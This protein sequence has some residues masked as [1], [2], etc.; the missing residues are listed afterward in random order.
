MDNYYDI[1]SHVSNSTLGELDMMISGRTFGANMQQVFNFGNLVDALLLEQHLVNHTERTLSL[2]TGGIASYTDDEWTRAINMR[3]AGRNHPILSSMISICDKQCVKM[4]DNFR[5]DGCGFSFSLP[6]RCKYDMVNYLHKIGA[7]L[8]T[9]A[10]KTQKAFVE[11]LSALNYDRQGAWY[12]DLGELDRFFYIGICKTPNRKGEHEIFVHAIE[13][14][15]EM[16]QS[17]KEK[18]QYL[19]TQYYFS[20]H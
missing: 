10:C 18:Y 13:R 2:N 11:S 14:G 19:A 20:I 9:T 17:G 6:V 3:R 5:I 7:D 16:Y 15:D 4:I 12:M 8:K 1:K